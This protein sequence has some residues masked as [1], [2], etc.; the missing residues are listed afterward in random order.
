M[1][2]RKSAAQL[3]KQ[4]QEQESAQPGQKQAEARGSQVSQ[5]H[6]RS[7][8]TDS[9]KATLHH[10]RH[11]VQV[12][13]QSP[14][15][16]GTVGTSSVERTSPPGGQGLHRLRKHLENNVENE[17][18]DASETP[19]D[20]RHLESGWKS[21]TMQQGWASQSFSKNSSDKEASN[22][23]QQNRASMLRCDLLLEGEVFQDSQ[24]A[25]QVLI[26][27]LWI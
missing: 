5:D 18:L 15:G 4:L 9:P 13:L 1:E 24:T 27:P 3:K 11:P 12:H 10:L 22:Q 6:G 23:E 20:D 2:I 8:E 21:S 26:Q 14:W 25:G 7:Q 19:G 16:E 17:K